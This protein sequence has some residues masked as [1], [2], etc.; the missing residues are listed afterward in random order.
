MTTTCRRKSH[1]EA[2]MGGSERLGELGLAFKLL[3]LSNWS[4]IFDSSFDI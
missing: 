3:H 2:R 4:K 1:A